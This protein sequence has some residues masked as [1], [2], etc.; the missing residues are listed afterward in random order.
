MYTANICLSAVSLLITS[1]ARIVYTIPGTV[2]VAA[3]NSPYLVT[4]CHDIYK[5]ITLEQNPQPPTSQ[6]LM[7]PVTT[8]KRNLSQDI[9]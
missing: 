8:K 2:R 1:L 5:D 6:Q 7:W 3:G 4:M 9:F